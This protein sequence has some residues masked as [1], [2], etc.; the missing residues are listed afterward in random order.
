MEPDRR[1]EIECGQTVDEQR[2]VSV[3]GLPNNWPQNSTQLYD[4]CFHVSASQ[5]LRDRSFM[6]KRSV[7]LSS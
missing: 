5:A 4:V 1:T 6:L 3:R 2:I 7:R